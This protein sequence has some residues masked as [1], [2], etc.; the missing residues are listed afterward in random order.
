MID[1]SINKNI[2]RIKL[3]LKTIP[4]TPGVYQYLDEKG[5]VIY[6][7]KARNLQ[8]RVNSYFNR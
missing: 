7:G 5:T 8:R 3:K 2:D 6:V 1:Q 4:E